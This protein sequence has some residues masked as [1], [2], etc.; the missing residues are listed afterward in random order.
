MAQPLFCDN[1]G[2]VKNPLG[3]CFVGDQDSRICQRNFNRDVAPFSGGCPSGDC[4]KDCSDVTTIY[5]SL[6]Q[7][8]PAGPGNGQGPIRRYQTCANVPN[9]A[10]YVS[11]RVL[12]DNITT[13]IGKNVSTDATPEQLKSV[14]SAVTSCLTATCGNARNQVDCK[15]K[16]EAVNLLINNTTPN[17]QGINDCL[18]ALC[19]HEFHALPFADA[20]IVGIGVSFLDVS[21]ATTLTLGHCSLHY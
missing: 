10:S 14:T 8:D 4:L 13:Y 6:A 9:V 2:N 21:V 16:C 15:D 7:N 1:I 3:C 5:Q 18:D 20:D 12:G 11:Q 19:L 17:V